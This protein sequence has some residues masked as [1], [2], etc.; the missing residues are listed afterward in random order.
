[1][2]HSPY[3]MV[4][5]NGLPLRRTAMKTLYHIGNKNKWNPKGSV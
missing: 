2:N 5:L 1:M 4:W 3:G